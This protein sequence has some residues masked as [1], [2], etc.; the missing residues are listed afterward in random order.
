MHA[1][2][3]SLSLD[4]FFVFWQLDFIPLSFYLKLIKKIV[5]HKKNAN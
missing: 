4:R 2:S 3:L 5:L 1:H